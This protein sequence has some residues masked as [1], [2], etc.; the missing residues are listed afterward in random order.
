M[1]LRADNSQ[2]PTPVFHNRYFSLIAQNTK[3]KKKRTPGIS[4]APAAHE[5]IHPTAGCK[6]NVAPPPAPRPMPTPRADS[7]PPG[8]R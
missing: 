7:L 2:Q 3:K 4:M 6:L 8:N 5:Y 1:Y